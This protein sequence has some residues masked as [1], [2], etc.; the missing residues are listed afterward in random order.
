MIGRAFSAVTGLMLPAFVAQRLSTTD[1]GTY[2]QAFLVASL[3]LYSLQLGLT[4]SLFYFVPRA[5]DDDARRDV[6]G[7]TQSTMTLVGLLCGVLVVLISPLIARLF[8]NAGLALLR[9]PL[10]LLAASLVASSPLEPALTAQGKTA[11]SAACLALSDLVRTVAMVGALLAGFG[12]SGLLWAAALSSLLRWIVSLVAAGAW[13][14]VSRLRTVGRVQWHYALPYGVGV[15]ALQQQTQMHQ[16][17]VASAVTPAEYALYAVGCTQIPLVALLYTPVAETLQVRLATMDR[18]GH[19]SD[20]AQAFSEAVGQL[21][22]LFLPLSAMLMALAP[23]AI[24][25]LFGPAYASAAGIMRIAAVSIAAAALPVD[26]VFKARARTGRLLAIY[27]AKL[28]VTWPVVAA[29][30]RLAGMRGAIGA[31]VLVEIGTRGFQLTVIASDLQTTVPRL[32]ASARLQRS[33]VVAVCVG[34]VTLG[35]VAVLSDGASRTRSAAACL[36]ASLAG[37]LPVVW[38]HVRAR[39]ASRLDA[40]PRQAA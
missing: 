15:L 38:P 7:R 2:K 35:T 33:V 16:V 8:D 37:A 13:R 14:S 40:G 9:L 10:G 27:L 20:A 32:V 28:A 31:H 3:A 19:R 22:A 21:G 39:L 23:A 4:Q 26:G 11:T 25:A 6:I 30:Q 34:A 1:Y 5:A 12:L 36:L 29:G 24:H 18:H 17:L